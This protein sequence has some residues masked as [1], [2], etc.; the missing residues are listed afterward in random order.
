VRRSDVVAV[1]RRRWRGRLV[2]AASALLVAG[3]G[4]T[5]LTAWAQSSQTTYYSFFTGVDTSRV[6][7]DPERQPVE[8]GLRFRSAVGG[9][10]DAV[11]FLKVPGDV[12]SHRVSVWTTDGTRLATATSS[13]ETSSGWQ[14]VK[15]S[16]P[17]S[18]A[19]GQTYVVSYHT[20]RYMS[21]T[22]YFGSP[23]KVGPLVAYAYANGVYAYGSDGYPNQ[24]WEASNYWVDLVFETTSQAASG[25]TG[26]PA[27][28]GS[29]SGAPGGTPTA[30]ASAAPSAAPG[31]PTPGPTGSTTGTLG[32]PVI[33][34]EGGPSYYGKFA[35][36]KAWTDPNFFPIGV[37]MESVIQSSDA[38]TDKAAGLNLYVN[39]TG[40]TDDSLIRAAGMYEFG[41]SGGGAETVGYNLADEV[42]M[43]YGP[44]YDQW[45]GQGGWNTCIPIQDQGGKCG[46]TVMQTFNNRMPNDGHPRYANYGKGVN[47]WESDQQAQVFVNKY[48][49]LV[50]SDMY[51]Y[52]DP[53]LCPNE[54]KTWLGIATDK[55]R[56]SS[57]YGLIIDKER[58]LDGMDGARMPIYAFVEVG[59]PFT[60]STAPTINGDQIAGAVMNSLIH[61]ARGVIYFNHSFGGACQSQHLLRDACGA[62]NRP[63]VT[64]TNQRIAALAPVLNSPSYQWTA[65]A[66]LDTMLK[67]SGGSYYLFAMPGANGGTGSQTLSLPAGLRASTAQVMFENRTVAINGGQFSDSFAAEYSYHIYKITP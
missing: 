28:S 23:R 1:P 45:S 5:A 43:V 25:P 9:S 56:R 32:L 51:F 30:S 46:Y 64:E 24:T 50:S 41:G 58:R 62:A 8:L 31:T 2:I 59:H 19:A 29:A 47:M 53:N 6:Q 27:P 35:S 38:A 63:K 17:I 44:G 48:Q 57:S 67:A 55:C 37:W 65:N 22:S 16:R 13:G 66:A 40:N 3:L 11:R 49:Q 15:L 42:D 7:A 4:A 52:T 26:S 39:P 20:T 33:A 34:W 60:E 21:S 54:A 10:I 36:T 12:N 18:V 61:G 14:Q